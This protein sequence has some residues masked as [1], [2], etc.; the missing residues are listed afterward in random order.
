MKKK[1][2]ENV[3]IIAIGCVGEIGK[4]LNFIEI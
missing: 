3:R 4:K 2:T 1:N